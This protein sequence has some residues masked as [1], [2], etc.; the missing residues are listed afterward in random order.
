MLAVNAI[1]MTHNLAHR[2]VCIKWLLH[3]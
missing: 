2:W 3:T 1:F